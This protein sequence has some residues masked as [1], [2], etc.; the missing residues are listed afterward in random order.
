MV[1]TIDKAISNINIVFSNSFTNEI[2]ICKFFPLGPWMDDILVGK[3]TM[4]ASSWKSHFQMI[5]EQVPLYE[6]ST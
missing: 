6:M 2:H 3:I 1:T 5:L 4:S